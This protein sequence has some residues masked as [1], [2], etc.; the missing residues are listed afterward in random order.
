M[1]LSPKFHLVT[2]VAAARQ[3]YFQLCRFSVLSEHLLSDADEQ[4]HGIARGICIAQFRG[5]LQRAGIAVCEPRVF[6]WAAA[7]GQSSARRGDHASGVPDP[8]AKSRALAQ[9]NRFVELVVPDRAIDGRE[10]SARGT[11]TNP[12]RTGSL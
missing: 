5:R 6:G 9:G 8:G 2:S 11:A 12:P 1:F 4:R 3:N 7:D 10:S